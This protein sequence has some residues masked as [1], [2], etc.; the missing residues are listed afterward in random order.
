MAATVGFGLSPS[1]ISSLTYA[2]EL[3]GLLESG[4]EVEVMLC[5]ITAMQSYCFSSFE[6]LRVADYQ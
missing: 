6:E 3:T 5:S 2:Y 1:A 4:G